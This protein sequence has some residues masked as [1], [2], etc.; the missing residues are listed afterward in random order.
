MRCAFEQM[1]AAP[2]ALSLTCRN[3]IPHARG[4]GSSSA[5]I[6]G[7]IVLA[8]ALVA[9]G[10]LL[11]DDDAVFRL[12]AEMEGHPDNVAPAFHGGFVISGRDS[13]E[14][15]ATSGSLDPRI[16]AVDRKSTRLNSSH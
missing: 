14:F 4:L 2:T 8:R 10:S 6:V 15:Y 5:A 1:H 12:A 7:G 16:S 3:V 13:G 11:M 9:G